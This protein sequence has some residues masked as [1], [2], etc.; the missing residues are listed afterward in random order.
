MAAVRGR[1]VLE[2]DRGD[3]VT[4]NWLLFAALVCVTTVR[5]TQLGIAARQRK[6]ADWAKERA[7][8]HTSKDSQ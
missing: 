3:P 4:E 2:P 1:T 6:R 8:S 7:A 5:L